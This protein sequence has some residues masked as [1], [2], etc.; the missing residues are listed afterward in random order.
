[1]LYVVWE[2]VQQLWH[3]T[4][5]SPRLHATSLQMLPHAIHIYLLTP[6]LHPSPSPSHLSPLVFPLRKLFK[7]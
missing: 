6:F 1:M 2:A 3:A 7:N 5:K 4:H